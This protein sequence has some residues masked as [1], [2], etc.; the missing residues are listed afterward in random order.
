MTKKKLGLGFTAGLAGQ[1][2]LKYGLQIQVSTFD[3]QK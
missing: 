1:T 3:L 2:G